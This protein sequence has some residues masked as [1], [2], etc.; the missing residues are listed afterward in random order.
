MGQ[1]YSNRV[2]YINHPNPNKIEYQTFLRRVNRYKYSH[3]QAMNTPYMWQWGDRKT[4][5]FHQLKATIIFIQV[6]NTDDKGK[7]ENLTKGMI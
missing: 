3:D 6:N 4:K 2:Y 5:K 1:R 7:E